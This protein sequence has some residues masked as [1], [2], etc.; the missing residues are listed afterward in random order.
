MSGA[1][2][3]IAWLWC[4]LVVQAY[5]AEPAIP[6][7][8]TDAK[9]F[10][11]AI[12]STAGPVTAPGDVTGLVVPH[13]LVAAD[14]IARAMRQVEG[15]RIDTVIVLSPDHFRRAHHAFATTF[16]DFQTVYGIVHTD[17]AV[18]ARLLQARDLVEASDLFDREHGVAAILP[19]LHRALPEAAIVPVAVALASHRADWD[20]FCA[21]LEPL[22]GPGTLVV[23][24]TDFSHYLTWS[25][26]VQRDQQTLAATA[27]GDP[28]AIASLRQPDQIDSVGA[29]YVQLRLQREV[30]GAGPVVLFNRNMQQYEVDPQP[31]TTSYVVEEFS[32]TL[33]RRIAPE[34]EGSQR[35]CFAGTPAPDA[36]LDGC[37]VVSSP[38]ASPSWPGLA[39]PSTSLLIKGRKDVDGRPPPAV[40]EGLADRMVTDL[41]RMRLLSL[42]GHDHIDQ[43]RA[44]IAAAEPPLFVLARGANASDA[45]ELQRSGAA[46]II[47]IS[48]HEATTKIDLVPGSWTPFVHSLGASVL[49]VR[50][51]QQGT[52]ALRL[53]PIAPSSADGNTSG[54]PAANSATNHRTDPR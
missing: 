5:A 54:P 32:P 17:G 43:V 8:Y 12:A 48:P 25:E 50:L 47:G 45:D 36:L 13:H 51:F 4:L 52:F 37:R 18:V 35:V 7:L 49:E 20:R 24:S 1:S 21:L 16:R 3:L 31:R 53:V 9:P 19:F 28:D 39:P 23:Q 2:K 6:S 38:A 41:G 22:L 10:D 42:A 40:T 30:F 44:A 11:D 14:L 33:N 46:A 26:A 34:M 15:Q 27:T 29:Y